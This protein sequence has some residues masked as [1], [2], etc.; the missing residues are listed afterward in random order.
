MV[1]DSTRTDDDTATENPSMSMTDGG[2]PPAFDEATLY[3]IVR[4][5]VEDALLSVVRT[6]V[7]VVLAVAVVWVGAIFLSLASPLGTAVGAIAVV[8]G[9]YNIADALDI[10]PPIRDWY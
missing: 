10:I 6:L 1:S 8:G 7:L 2:A 3:V 9:I 4:H 5:A